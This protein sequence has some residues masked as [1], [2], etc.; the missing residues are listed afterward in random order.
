MA[1]SLFDRS[2]LSCYYCKG[3][4]LNNAR[5]PITRR[6]I[7]SS[8]T[9]TPEI[10]KGLEGV[11]FTVSNVSAI[12]GQAGKLVYRGIPIEALAEHS[13][14]EETS[15]LLIEGRLPTQG[16]LDTFVQT[17]R[18]NMDIPG[19]VVDALRK[20]PKSTHPMDALRMG[21]SALVGFDAEVMDPYEGLALMAKDEESR[22]AYWEKGKRIG[23]RLISKFP[24][25]VSAWY[26]IRQGLPVIDPLPDLS[27]AGNFLYMMFGEKPS[28]TAE[29][30]MDVALILHAAH[31]MSAS[32][33][34][35]VVIASTAVD[36]Y[37]AIA[38]AIGA[39]KGPLHGGANQLVLAQLREIESHGGVG[40]V[41][42]WLDDLLARKGRVMGFGHR[43]YK[44]YDPRARILKR[45][46]GELA[47]EKE[48][49]LY[50]IALKLEEINIQKL[51]GK[52]IFPNVDFYSG[53]VYGAL[54]IPSDFFT[55]IFAVARV[56]GWVADVL[57]YW[58]E[59]R[60]IRPRAWYADQVWDRPYIPL[61]EREGQKQE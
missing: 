61:K 46:A 58:K 11:Y 34:S 45:W 17:M 32:T 39:L 18:R 5:L 55:P 24:T 8:V 44:A 60:L 30:V 33:F 2:L 40:A 51:G 47:K 36:M 53:L 43:V 35:A 19:Q 38:G 4:N 9:Q 22:K 56:S 12:D 37:A 20:L 50:E 23:I 1:Y 13:S 29:R 52:G 41:E 14:F 6:F 25:L 27:H 10:H 54:G 49:E 15:F 28:P 42:T 3:A 59:N 31:G 16:G 21:V 48:R 57:E 7:M 26:R